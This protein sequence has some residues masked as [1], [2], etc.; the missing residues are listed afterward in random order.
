MH[1]AV[2]APVGAASAPFTRERLQQRHG[3]VLELVAVLLGQSSRAAN[4][5]RFADDVVVP[6][7]QQIEAR[8]EP[9]FHERDGEVGDVYAHPL[10]VQLVGRGDSR[11]TSAEG[12]EYYVALVGGRCD[13]TFEEHLAASE[14]G[15]PGVPLRGSRLG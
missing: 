1:D 7:G 13:D 6:A 12:V 15:S 3:P 14:W 10:A 9:V 8:L 4:V 11:A 2:D 5:Q